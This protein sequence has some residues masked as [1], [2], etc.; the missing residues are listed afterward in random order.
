MFSVLC[1]TLTPD[2]VNDRW[3]ETGVLRP[4]QKNLSPANTYHIARLQR[5]VL[6]CVRIRACACRTLCV[7]GSASVFMAVVCQPE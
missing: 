3:V 6:L 7:N 5:P 2:F 4:R 1:L